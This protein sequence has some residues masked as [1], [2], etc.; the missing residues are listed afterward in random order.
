MSLK[1]RNPKVDTQPDLFG[2]ESPVIVP[3]D[4]LSENE[5]K[6]LPREAFSQKEFNELDEDLQEW[7]HEHDGMSAARIKDMIDA[8]VSRHEW[9]ISLDE[10]AQQH[11]G[12]FDMLISEVEVKQVRRYYKDEF[13]NFL[14]HF[15]AE[16]FSQDQI[17]DALEEA[18]HD[19]NNYTFSYNTDEYGGAFLRS[20]EF[21]SFYMEVNDLHDL[22]EDMHS[23]EIEAALEEINRKTDLT[24]DLGDIEKALEKK[25]EAFDIQEY[26]AHYADADLDWDKL[27]E[28]VKETLS[29]EEPAG[30]ATSEEV[31]VSKR[32]VHKFKDGS[33][34]LDLL[35]SELPTEG[36]AMGMCIGRPEMGYIRAVRQGDTK[37]LSLRT[38]AGRPKFTIEA[39]IKQGTPL[40]PTPAIYRISRI[41]QIKGKANRLPGWDLGKEGR[42][43]LKRDEVEK[44]KELLNVLDIPPESVSD[45]RPALQMLETG[46]TP[47]TNPSGRT[48]TTC[49]APKGRRDFCTPVDQ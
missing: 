3:L 37:I 42:G 38:Q 43:D 4:E 32:I 33:Y 35:P 24:L 34:V 39:S 9:A 17:K 31:P 21:A 20:N 13:E 15:Q 27:E 2:G 12:T 44:I 47:K 22:T 10:A 18:V 36:K 46:I 49:R 16:G 6:A 8:F 48:C 14:E 29:G 40:E 11:E 19:S 30:P 23:D 28:A 1:R 25:Y 7:I 26:S 5:I 45:L 41:N